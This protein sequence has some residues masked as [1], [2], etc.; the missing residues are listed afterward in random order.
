MTDYLIKSL[1]A[2]AFLGTISTS[3]FS[4]M[5]LMGKIEHKTA[6]EKLRKIHKWSGIAS[7]LILAPLVYFGAD[8]LSELGDGLSV[9]AALHFVLAALLLAV[10]LL[11]VL[12]VWF[13]KGFLRYATG[14]GM[15]IFAMALA[16]FLITAGFYFIQL[17]AA[18]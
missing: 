1:I 15:A 18:K 11:K 17:A 16:I 13:Y 7:L 8:F 9:R 4:M 2:V 10:I 14:L 3:F 6:P 12:V 5:A